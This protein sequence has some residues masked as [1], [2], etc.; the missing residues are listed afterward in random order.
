VTFTEEPAALRLCFGSGCAGL[1]FA[2]I[3]RGKFGQLLSISF[4]GSE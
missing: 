2:T 4:S 3:L 1:R